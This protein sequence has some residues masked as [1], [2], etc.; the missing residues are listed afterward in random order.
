M[1][2]RT[3]PARAPA[4]SAAILGFNLRLKEPY[5]VFV[6][7]FHQEQLALGA[8]RLLL[9]ALRDQRIEIGR[10]LFGTQDAS[11]ALRFFLSRPKRARHLEQDVGIRKVNREIG[12]LR[13]NQ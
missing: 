4:S 10:R 11:K 3:L 7:L 2:A 9:G 12:D 5:L 8:E 6:T 1:V 13:D